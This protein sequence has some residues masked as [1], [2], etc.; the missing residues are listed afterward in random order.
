MGKAS[1]RIRNE[2]HRLVMGQHVKVSGI[3][4]W[5]FF[6]VNHLAFEDRLLHFGLVNIG[7]RNFKQIVIQYNHISLTCPI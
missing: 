1:G 4:T 2:F 6:L 7:R 3:G 5:L